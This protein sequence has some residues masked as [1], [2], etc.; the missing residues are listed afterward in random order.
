MLDGQFDFPVYWQVLKT[1]ARNEATMADLANLVTQSDAYYGSSAI[2]APFLGNHD[3]AR[4]I[5]HANGDISDQWG[6]NAKEQGWTNPPKSP[7]SYVPYQ[8][9]QL[10]FTFL[11]TDY[12]VPLTYYGDE[13]GLPGAGDPDNRRLM[14]FGTTLS[15]FEA[16]TLQYLQKVF[17]LRKAHEALR[18]NSRVMLLGTDPDVLVYGKIGPTEKAVVALNRSGSSRTVTVSVSGLSLASGAALTDAIGGSTATVSG[19]SLT[20]TLPAYTAAIYF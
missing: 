17:S 8:K 15:T 3:V 18:S 14:K 19:S 13:I 9:L 6:N 4:F 2:M 11:A 16:S 20:L 10:A 5:S 1:F 12:G 7:G